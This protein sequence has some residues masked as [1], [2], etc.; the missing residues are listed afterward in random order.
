MIPKAV[1]SHSPSSGYLFYFGLKG[2]RK[3]DSRED[4]HII[5]DTLNS[6]IRKI[7]AQSLNYKVKET[8]GW[9]GG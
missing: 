7:P 2:M 5:T 3:L 6:L 9:Q 4:I 8:F 1:C